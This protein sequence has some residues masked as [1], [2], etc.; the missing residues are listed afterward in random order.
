MVNVIVIVTLCWGVSAF[1]AFQAV[2]T[3]WRPPRTEETDTQY[4]LKGRSRAWGRARFLF[5]S[6]AMA[7]IGLYILALALEWR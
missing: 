6:V 1:F 4:L 7:L 2:R 3:P 5:F